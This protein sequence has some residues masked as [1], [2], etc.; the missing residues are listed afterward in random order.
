MSETMSIKIFPCIKVERK[1]KLLFLHRTRIEIK[2]KTNIKTKPSKECS[3]G[4][5]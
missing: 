3:F 4:I 2:T 1:I 5:T